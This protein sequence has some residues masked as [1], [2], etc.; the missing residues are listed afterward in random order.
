M[1]RWALLALLACG[2]GPRSVD[3]AGSA[4]QVVEQARARPTPDPVRARLHV[5]L[6]SGTLDVAGGTGAVLITDRP[7]RG[8]LAILG[9]LGGP[10]ATLTSDGVG[11]AVA[12]PRD[13]RLLSSPEADAILRE[14]TEGLLGLDDLVGLLLGDLPFDQGEVK[15]QT[16][17][18]GGLVEALLEGPDGTRL[19]VVLEPRFATPVSA[20]VYE[21]TGRE[22]LAATFEP[23]EPQPDGTV[24]PTRVGLVVAA[25]ALELD[26]RFK[27]WELL[28]EVPPV[29]D[30]TPPEGWSVEPL[31]TGW[32]GA[33]SETPGEHP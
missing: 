29:F 20:T 30:L 33:L 24:L 13:R 8:H 26:L 14:A 19:V 15:R 7:G 23:F 16:L 3:A 18:E 6:D 25:L 28:T 21:R 11:L 9:P 12:L 4:L 17:L 31:A 2:P 22:L 5:A 1:S 10:M 32:M 27:S